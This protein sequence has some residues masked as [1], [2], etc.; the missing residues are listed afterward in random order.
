LERYWVPSSPASA[1]FGTQIANQFIRVRVGGDVAFFNG[2]LKCLIE[3]NLLAE[4]HRQFIHSRTVGFDELTAAL[5]EQTFEMLSDQS[6]TSRKEM[7]DFAVRLAEC[8][9]ATFA[10]GMGLTQHAT[11][12]ENVQSVVN[13]ALALGQLGRR[14]AGV[15]PLRGQS[16]V[17]SAGEC[18]VAPT[19]FPGGESI[20]DESAARLSEAW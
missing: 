18:G 3:E 7:N 12:T 17:Q 15:A 9:N 4:R 2:V 20:N 16:S 13:L 19:I 1:L 10:W 8:E 6:G 11:G 5:H 14:G